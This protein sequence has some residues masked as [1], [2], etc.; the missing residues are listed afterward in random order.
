MRHFSTFLLGLL[1]LV[2]YPAAEAEDAAPTVTSPGAVISMV[3][4][5]FSYRITATGHPTSFG[6]CSVSDDLMYDQSKG[7]FS[8]VPSQTYT[9]TLPISATNGSGTGS[10]NFTIDIEYDLA[11]TLLYDFNTTPTTPAGYVGVNPGVYTLG[12]DGNFYIV[13]SHG[14]DR[15]FFILRFTPQG[16]LITDQA[17]NFY[18]TVAQSSGSDLPTKIVRISPAGQISYLYRFT[19]ESEGIPY[20]ALCL[21]HDGNLY[22]EL[23]HGVEGTGGAIF[24][25]SPDG[26]FTILH[27]LDSATEGAVPFALVEGADGNLYGVANTGGLGGGGSVFEVTP[28]GEF[29]VLQSFSSGSASSNPCGA[30]VTGADGNLYGTTGYVVGYDSRIPN[31]QSS[32]YRVVPGGPVTVLRSLDFSTDRQRYPDS[33]VRSADGTL[34][35]FGALDLIS[36]DLRRYALDGSSTSVHRFQDVQHP[37]DLRPT[38][39]AD[40]NIYCTAGYGGIIS[41]L[42]GFVR[43]NTK[44]EQ[45]GHPGFFSGELTLTKDVSYLTLGNGNTFGYYSYLSDPH[46]IYHFDMGYEYWFDAADSHNGVYLYDFQSSDFFYTSPTFPFPYLYDFNLNTVLYYYPNPDDPSRYD[47]NGLRYFYRFDTGQIITK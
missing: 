40:G 20:S 6:A 27:V 14:Y 36:Q 18:G 44:P 24:R 34:Y 1:L 10:E 7:L 23:H 35:G 16:Q 29:K 38:V 43:I 31:A 32:F 22:G 8:G 42:G 28:G 47:T 46:Y 11:M 15:N 2:A 25:L 17:G 45:I 26:T 21:A 30:L 41:T 4:Q 13:N 5:P 9:Y 3:G 33:L 37:M 12:A 39:G 19:D